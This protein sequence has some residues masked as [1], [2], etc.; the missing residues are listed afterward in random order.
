MIE[1][2]G[3]AG[4]VRQIKIYLG[5]QFRLFL[6]EKDWKVLPMAAVIAFMV[7]YVVGKNMFLNMEGTKIGSLAF[8]C[9]CIWNGFFNSIQVVCKERPII[10]R[11]HRS[12]MH[13]SS[14]LAAHLIFQALL[15]MLQVVI[16]LVI[17]KLCGVRFPRQGVVTGNFFVD[18]F[19]T[20]FLITFAS[21]MLALMVSCIV[22]TTMS[23][24]TVMPFLLI[25]QL[26][27]AGVA[28]P[29]HGFPDKL[30]NATISKWGVY[31]VCAQS[32]YN[33]LPTTL[34]DKELS[35]LEG[36]EWVQGILKDFELLDSEELEAAWGDVYSE[37]EREVEEKMQVSAY[38]SSRKNVAKE[39]GILIAFAA[40]YALIGMAALEFVDFDKR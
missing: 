28:F 35:M 38:D 36:T 40:L 5:K 39:W 8:V 7:A 31:A 6:H 17:Y 23:A 33:S 24:M 32:N 29:L 13:I 3:H 11:E 10:K 15:C 20:L 2:S 18:F 25:V 1:S 26:V 12:G 14:Y 4:R 37:L 34:L 19:V 27:F 9:V 22:R 30:S 16:S 21:D